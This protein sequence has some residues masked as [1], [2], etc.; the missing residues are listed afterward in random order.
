MQHTYGNGSAHQKIIISPC[1][2]ELF[3][4]PL[5]LI[6]AILGP[7]AGFDDVSNH[8]HLIPAVLPQPLLD[9]GSDALHI[10]GDVIGPVGSWDLKPLQNGTEDVLLQL[11]IPGIGLHAAGISEGRPI[12]LFVVPDEVEIYA[13]ILMV[14]I[15]LEQ[16]SRLKK[17]DRFQKTDVSL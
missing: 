8:L 14:N 5:F 15:H 6:A 1:A 3:A 4:L 17:M 10:V 11:S 7:R 12:D 13:A 2:E 16:F 9:D